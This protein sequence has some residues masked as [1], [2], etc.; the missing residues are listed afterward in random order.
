MLAGV[1]KHGDWNEYTIRCE[2]PRVRLWLNGTMTVD[3]TEADEKVER[4]GV[5]GLQ[6][7]GGAK[8]RV[9]YKDIRIEE[10]GAKK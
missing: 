1:V 2:G 7:H 5:I 10:L 9:S 3:Y 4:S 8:A 6:I